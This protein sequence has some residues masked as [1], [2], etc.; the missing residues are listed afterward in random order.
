ML[1]AI[2]KEVIQMLYYERAEKL[3][4]IIIRLISIQKLYGL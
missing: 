1:V 3:F 4:G 2:T